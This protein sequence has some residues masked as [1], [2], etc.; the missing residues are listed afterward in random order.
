MNEV[1][2]KVNSSKAWVLASRPKTLSGAAVPVMIGTALAMRDTLYDI[3][4]VPAILC[5]LF[6]FLM[7]IDANFINDYFDFVKGTDDET[8]LGPKRACAQGWIT[9]SAMRRGI[10]LTTILSCMVGLPLVFYGGWQMIVVGAVCVLF[11]FLYTTCLSYMGLGDVLVVLFFGI[12]PVCFTYYLDMPSGTPLFGSEVVWISLA[13]GLVIDTLLIVNNYR[14]IDN[15]RRAGKKTLVVRIGA[16]ASE[17]LYLGLG[18]SACVLSLALFYYKS[19]WAAFL[20][21]IY[22]VMH[23][24]TYREMLRIRKGAELNRV[25][26][27]TARNMFF[28]GLLQSVGLIIGV[29]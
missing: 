27:M 20:P 2:V 24:H 17:N 9:K 5:F 8:R 21:L 28:Y 6:A 11:C 18:L 14:D 1:S 23:I 22:L 29:Q 25:L 13:C 16:K 3:R 19:V 26:G 10:V 7:Q 15:D 4:F 12:V